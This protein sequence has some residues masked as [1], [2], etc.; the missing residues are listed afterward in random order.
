MMHCVP[1]A[2]KVLDMLRK[3]GFTTFAEL[4]ETTGVKSFPANATGTLFVPTNAVR[5][6]SAAPRPVTARCM[7]CHQMMRQ[8]R[9]RLACRPH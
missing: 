1:Q 2:D 8:R 7:L 6:S 3:E 9:Q 4:V 5:R